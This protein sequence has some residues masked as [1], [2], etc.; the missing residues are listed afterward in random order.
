MALTV[1]LTALAVLSMVVTA[2]AT[3][4][5]P[6][7][8]AA[9]VCVAC[10]APAA[11]DTAE[12]ARLRKGEILTVQAQELDAAGTTR[13]TVEVSALLPHR[14]AEVWTVLTDFA[15]RPR[16]QPSTREVAVV[17]VDGPRVWVDEW[18]RFFLFD[19]RYRLALT[20][21]TEAGTIEFAMDEESPHDIGDVRG[22]WRLR[23]VD[24]GR[25]TLVAYR[26]W[27]DFGH[28][29]PRWLQRALL[30]YSLPGLLESLR[31]EADRLRPDPA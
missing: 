2:L 10:A 29:L 17:R 20:L 3:V 27:I 6:P 16:W 5:L 1:F 28:G 4:E 26:A 9:P 22:H 24:E 30:R 23:H 12:L 13:H 7:S 31:T 11:D 14:P 19:V 21:D 15:G 25:R 8:L 18:A